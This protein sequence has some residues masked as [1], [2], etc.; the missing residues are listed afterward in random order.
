MVSFEFPPRNAI[1]KHNLMNFQKLSGLPPT[2]WVKGEF[3]ANPP[4]LASQSC[5]AMLEPPV[6]R[7][8]LGSGFFYSRQKSP[9][10]P[11]NFPIEMHIL[12]MVAWNYQPTIIK[13]NRIVLN[14][15]YLSFILHEYSIHMPLSSQHNSTLCNI[16]PLSSHYHPI[17]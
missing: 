7:W 11:W 3:L 13:T 2:S 12:Q 5:F 8:W 10:N 1:G 16:I 6:T 9:L 15:I 14:R 17:I 4:S